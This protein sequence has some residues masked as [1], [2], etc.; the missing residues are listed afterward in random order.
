MYTY[1]TY[2]GDRGNQLNMIWVDNA[3]SIRNGPSETKRRMRGADGSGGRCDDT[4]P[5]RRERDEFT[6]RAFRCDYRR[7]S[8]GGHRV[9]AAVVVCVRR[10]GQGPEI[11]GTEQMHGMEGGGGR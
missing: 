3:S 4:G 10:C 2:E 6:E 1:C 7:R 9:V 5:D 11:S 8:E